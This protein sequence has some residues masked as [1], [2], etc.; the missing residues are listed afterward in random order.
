MCLE[1]ELYI[2]VLGEVWFA[3]AFLEQLVHQI[4]FEETELSEV[5][6]DI[7]HD[8]SV[9][10]VCYILELDLS[11]NL[12]VI[13]QFLQFFIQIKHLKFSL[14]DTLH[15]LLLVFLLDKLFQDLL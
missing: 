11:E 8:Y 10:E 12:V 2:F 6:T 1:S 15:L 7:V 13:N 5:L 14:F 3:I 9:H 4:V